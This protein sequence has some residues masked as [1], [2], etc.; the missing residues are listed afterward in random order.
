MTETR[1]HLAPEQRFW[2]KVFI[3][4]DYD[5]TD[6]CWTWT[7]S[8]RKPFGY[9]QMRWGGGM[10]YAH[11][12]SFEIHYH[13]PTMWVLHK[14]DNPACVR[15]SHL[16]EGTLEDN[17]KDAAAKGRTANQNTSKTHCKHGHEFTEENT[18]RRSAG[19]QCI[20]CKVN[21]R[22]GA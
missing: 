13:T 20:T 12:V 2:R 21:Q 18:Y 11:R 8:I 19:R 5:V 6:A 22:K 16:F 4:D 1:E 15:P 10:E 3:P 7:A 9:G 17:N 14:C